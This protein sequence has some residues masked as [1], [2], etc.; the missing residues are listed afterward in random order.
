MAHLVWAIPKVA[1]DD[2]SVNLA[3]RLE[4][5]PLDLTR[6][7]FPFSIMESPAE[8]YPRYSSLFSPSIR[9]GITF[10]ANLLGFLTGEKIADPTSGFRAYNKKMIKIFSQYYPH[11]FPEPEAIA[12]ARRYSARI[13][14]VAVKMRKRQSGKSSI[15]YLKTFYYMIKV[16]FAIFLDKLKTC[17]RG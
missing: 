7:V 8:S 5:F 15:R 13:R 17:K 3:S 2:I 4:T 11:D 14:E 9:I 12:V 16:A 10:F 6:N 1:S